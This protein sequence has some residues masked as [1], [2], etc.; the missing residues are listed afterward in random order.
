MSQASQISRYRPAVIAVTGAAAAFGIWTLY[1]TFTEQ[2]TKAPLHR[3]NAVRRSRTISAEEL[4]VEASGPRHGEPFGAAVIKRNNIPIARIVFGRG[5]VMELVWN[6]SGIVW[7]I[8]P[9]G[10]CYA[11][12]TIV[13]DL[14]VWLRKHKIHSLPSHWETLAT[15]SSLTLDKPLR[16]TTLC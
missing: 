4:V 8:S 7:L 10:Q 11:H 14:L 6:M 13:M 16:R 3:S 5:T 15:M 1:S 2:S 9:Y 12:R